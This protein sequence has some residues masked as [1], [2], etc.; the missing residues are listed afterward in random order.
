MEAVGEEASEAP[1]RLG[2]LP[3]CCSN[4]SGV[5]R[6]TVLRVSGSVALGPQELASS[7]TI[8]ELKQR[9]GNGQPTQLMLEKEVL[10]DEE[11]LEKLPPV[12]L[13]TA[14]FNKFEDEE[15]CEEIACKFLV[16]ARI[17]SGTFGTVFKAQPRDQEGFVAIKKIV[18]DEYADGIPGSAIREISLLRQLQHPNVVQLL[19]VHHAR[20]SL[21]LVF[22]L[23]DMD[24]RAYLKW[25]GPFKD[26]CTLRKASRQLFAGLHCCH[27]RRILHRD[28]KPQNILICL[29]TMTLKLADFGLARVFS[30]PL[31]PYTQEVVSLW[32]RAPELLLGQS[33]CGVSVDTW[34]LGCIFGEMATGRPMFNGDSEIDTLFRIFR[35]LG[36]PTE[37]VWPGVGQLPHFHNKIFPSWE[38][39]ELMEV[40]RQ[41]PALGEV[42]AN[43]LR[44]CLSY[45]PDGR[46]TMR[47][48]T[49]HDFFEVR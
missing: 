48:L 32:Y 22:E 46:P 40:R 35:L 45:N 26:T 38:D 49:Q 14:V 9:I 25:H 47:R 33:C 15:V 30:M 21:F 3:Q 17:G 24:L 18:L 44:L 5:V 42:G 43:L 8:R 7:L 2:D 11:T 41:G 6:V 31:R 16:L 36:T 28:L 19:E 27:S 34:A 20:T 23:L 39:S 1:V 10:Q 13:L 29:D 4:P 12:C 37:E